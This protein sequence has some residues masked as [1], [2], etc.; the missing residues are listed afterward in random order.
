MIQNKMNYKLINLTALVL[1]IYLL[2]SSISIWGGTA[3]KIL[4]AFT[5]FIVGFAFAYALFYHDCKSLYCEI[6]TP[7]I[8]M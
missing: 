3:L 2:L 5:P 8:T 7:I 1:L 4:K 6:F